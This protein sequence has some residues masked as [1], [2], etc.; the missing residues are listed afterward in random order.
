VRHESRPH[1]H[2]ALG[3]GVNSIPEA[4]RA[5]ASALQAIDERV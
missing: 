5:V 4:N 2:S 3:E 1:L